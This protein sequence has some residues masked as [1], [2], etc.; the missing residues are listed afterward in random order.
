MQIF[1]DGPKTTKV[2][3]VV[4]ARGGLEPAVSRSGTL[5]LSK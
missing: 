1:G 3:F 4:V 5:V 2:Y